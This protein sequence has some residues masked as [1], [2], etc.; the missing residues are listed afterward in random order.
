MCFR[1]SLSAPRRTQTYAYKIVREPD[2]LGCSN[3]AMGA[4]LFKSKVFTNHSWSLGVWVHRK[5]PYP[6]HIWSR[7]GYNHRVM[8]A[9]SGIYV[10]TKIP[11]QLLNSRDVLVEMEVVPADFLYTDRNH[12]VATYEKARIK[13]VLQRGPATIGRYNTW[14]TPYAFAG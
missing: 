2:I 6:V 10:Y 9:R 4:Q 14:T 3:V 1:I 7:V 5:G 11:E 8:N 12:S 13:R